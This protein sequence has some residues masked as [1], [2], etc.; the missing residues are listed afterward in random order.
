M[1][2]IINR[3]TLKKCNLKV[4]HEIPH[5]VCLHDG[6]SQFSNWNPFSICEHKNNRSVPVP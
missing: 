4:A 5:M 2:Q 1:V 6:V 3:F